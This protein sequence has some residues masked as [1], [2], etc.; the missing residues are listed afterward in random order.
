MEKT[1]KSNSKRNI[2]KL[3]DNFR[4]SI[5]DYAI[6]HN[7][8]CAHA[9]IALYATG[10]RPAEI[11]KGIVVNF[12]DKT[13]V[14]EFRILGSKLNRAQKRG[15]AIRKIKIQITDKN[16]RFYSHITEVFKNNPGSY[17]YKIKTESGKA[18]S[19]YISKISK[20]L[21]PR[22]K[23]HVSAYSFRHAKASDLKNNDYSD[24]EI[25]Q[26]LGHAST[27]AQQSYG[28]RNKKNR[29]GFDD[30]ADV[31][32]SA[33]PRENDRLLRIKI[34]NKNKASQ[35]LSESI[36]STTPATTAPVRK[37]KR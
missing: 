26:V 37:F 10:C 24:I 34:A 1:K 33:K 11:E 32:T 13:N 6:S 36:S 20:E 35:K 8:K 7:L 15:I 25:A 28:R 19:G 23:H 27:R 9:L 5:L 18:F 12:D 21:W 2:S 14:L 30:I 4:E 17:D 22:K 3:N 31:E 16:E 29:G